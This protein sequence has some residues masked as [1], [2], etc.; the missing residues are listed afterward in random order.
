M[1]RRAWAWRKCHAA[2]LEQLSGC[3]ACSLGAVTE[4]RGDL[5]FMTLDEVTAMLNHTRISIFKNDI[6]GFEYELIGGQGCA[7]SAAKSENRK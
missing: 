2:P 1:V 7:A 6:E 4:T 3:R 5:Q